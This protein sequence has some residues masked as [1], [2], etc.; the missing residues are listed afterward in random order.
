MLLKNPEPLSWS[1]FKKTVH[2]P[3]QTQRK[4]YLR[5]TTQSKHTNGTQPLVYLQVFKLLTL[6]S[7]PQVS[8]AFSSL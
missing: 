3:Q 1:V 2:I 5:A 8:C 7:V 4:Q 6:T